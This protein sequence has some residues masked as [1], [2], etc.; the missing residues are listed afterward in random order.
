MPIMTPGATDGV[1][2]TAAGIATYGI[3]AVF[4]DSNGNGIHGLNEHVKVQS[5]LDDR[6]FHYALIKLYA[7]Q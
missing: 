7:D 5:L 6:K 1:F 4:T 2:L 3:D